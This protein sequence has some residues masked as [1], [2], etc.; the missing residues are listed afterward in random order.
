MD[1]PAG[2][3]IP[4]L[5]NECTRPVETA[6][7]RMGKETADPLGSNRSPNTGH[8]SICICKNCTLS[9]EPEV[10]RR[11]SFC[12]AASGQPLAD[13]GL[14]QLQSSELGYNTNSHVVS[15]L[16]VQ[17]FTNR[18]MTPKIIESFKVF[19]ASTKSTPNNS[20]SFGT[21]L[22]RLSREFT[23]LTLYEF[24]HILKVSKVVRE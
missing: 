24:R 4:F 16:S 19:F 7:T 20:Q 8:S 14:F 18:G 17:F 13:R 10:T 12:I 5:A 21:C 9:R 23:A 11:L 15:A 6:I 3:A 2:K 1:F 22:S